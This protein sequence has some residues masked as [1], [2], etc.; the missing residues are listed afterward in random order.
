[1]FVS[2]PAPQRAACLLPAA[3][4]CL[5]ATWPIGAAA[6]TV[7]AARAAQTMV[8]TGNPLQR[9]ELAQ[10]VSVLTG[11]GLLIRRASTLGETLDGLPGVASTWFGPNSNRP[12][13]RGL[14]GDRVRVLDNG[15]AS[16]DASSLSFDHAVPID[17]LVVERLEVLRGPAALLYGGNATGGVVNTIDNR[18]PRSPQQGLGG[19]AELRL[20]GAAAERSVGAVLEG[21]AGA[22]T[23]HVDAFNRETSDLR[24]PL[25]TPVEDGTP[26]D[27]A[28]RVRNSQ[29]DA[30]G[31]AVG[32]SWF[33][34]D[35]FVGASID[36]Y[37]NT[38]GVTVEP[39]VTI[40][41]KRERYASAGEWNWAGAPVS[42]L[43]FSASRTEY[44]HQEV[45]GTGEVGTTFTSTGDEARIELRHAPIGPLNGVVG[46]QAE[47][48]RFSALGE[49]AFVP[50]TRTRSTAVFLLEEMKLGEGTLS[51][52]LRTERVQVE[53]SGDA[54][55][56]EDPRFG[57][58]QRRSFSPTSASLSA[59]WP[60][61]SGF[62]VNASAGRTQ[63]APAYYE[64]YANGLHIATGA[65]EV[66]DP[67]L[68]VESSRHVEIGTSWKQGPNSL[69]AQIFSTRFSNFISL[70]ATGRNIDV[71]GEDGALSSVPEYAFR[72]VSARLQGLEVEGRWRVA[73]LPWA[74][75][76][77][78]GLDG[79]RGDN[80]DTGEPLPRI[81]PYRVS[82][83]VEAAQGPWQLGAGVRYAA[84]QD[85]VPSTDVATPS[86]TMLNLWLT[87]K[88][89]LALAET[90]WFAR[91]DNLTDEL[92]FSSSSIGT[93]RGLAPLPGRSATAGL[94]IAF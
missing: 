56:A 37:R 73:E 60:L 55:D 94:R 24:V 26:L 29:A 5:A 81:A 79:V 66:G 16:V 62:S 83:G 8:I 4:W 61:G 2:D 33:A 85:R 22:V 91:A 52:G 71:V 36:T 67:T 18:I 27:P 13:I 31:G 92:A 19:R 75:D 63:R 48:L 50:D 58:A 6:Q 45:E 64:L 25:F 93:I 59:L 17:P 35:G 69:K 46:L 32:A 74:L 30:R 51:A 44:E 76:L 1:M 9:G 57:A 12:T 43:S 21:G 53:S 68:G 23:W 11:D 40:R 7:E 90:T 42:R 80:R 49:E 10:P 78:A 14:D 86:Y 28:T 65:F 38:Y 84:E 82:A 70:D 77:L 39:D 20:G 41:M 87:W 89:R 72:G 34:G 88:S 54:A 3:V 15:G 47:S